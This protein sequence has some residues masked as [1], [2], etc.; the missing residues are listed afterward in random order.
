VQETLDYC[1]LNMAFA[2]AG[3]ALGGLANLF[4]K[5]LTACFQ[6]QNFDVALRRSAARSIDG[7][8]GN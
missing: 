6:I 7:D 4:R 3:P 2:R 1:L 5:P 8:R